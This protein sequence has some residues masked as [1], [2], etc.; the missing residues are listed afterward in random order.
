MTVAETFGVTADQIS[1]LLETHW[2]DWTLQA[3]DL[4]LVPHPGRL[5]DWL[6]TAEPHEADR[7]LRGLAQLSDAEAGASR[8]AGLVLAWV[9]MPAATILAH[10]LRSMSQDIDFHVAAQ[11]WI[12]VRT[13]PWQTTGR[14]AANLK[15]NLRKRVVKDLTSTAPYLPLDDSRLAAVEISPDAIEELIEILGDGLNAEVIDQDDFDLLMAVLDA[16]DEL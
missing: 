11:L 6:R 9:M 4:A 14:V 10:Q 2:V 15:L 1:D 7:V 16:A 3:P 8:E 13:Y 12:A 5:C